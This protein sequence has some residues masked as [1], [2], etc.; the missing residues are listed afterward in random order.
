[1]A[2]L[3]ARAAGGDRVID[4]LF[5]L[6]ESYLD[7]SARPTIRAAKARYGCNTRRGSRAT[8]ASCEL[9]PALAD[10]RQG[11]YRYRGAG[12]LPIH[13]RGTDAPR[14]QAA[15]LR[16][17]RR[18]QQPSVDAAPGP[19]GSGRPTRPHTRDRAGLAA[20]RR[21]V[22]APGR[23]R[24][25]PRRWP[26]AGIPRMARPGAAEAGEMAAVRPGAARGPDA[27]TKP[28]RTRAT[29]PAWPTTNC[30]PGRSPRR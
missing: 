1:M 8:R 10:Y 15:G 27:R 6:P 30:W 24:R 12:V 21:A 4:L 16:Q 23:R 3:I 17:A 25:W 26:A 13:P 2:S 22:A 5:H 14:D 20:D 19:H 11:R 18:V 28:N 9:P 7:R 29:A